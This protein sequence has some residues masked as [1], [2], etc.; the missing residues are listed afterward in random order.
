MMAV[1]L[2]ELHSV[3]GRKPAIP[4][5]ESDRIREGAHRAAPKAGAVTLAIA[6]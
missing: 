5:V 3:D 1:R 4:F 2:L 6:N